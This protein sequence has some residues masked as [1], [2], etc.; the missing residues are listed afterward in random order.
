MPRRPMS[1][2]SLQLWLPEEPALATRE[3]LKHMRKFVWEG[4][5]LPAVRDQAN[6]ILEGVPGKAWRWQMHQL[7]NWVRD[8]ITYRLDPNGLETVQRADITLEL[9]YGD[10]DDFCVLLSTLLECCGYWTA[11]RALGFDQPGEFS[12]VIV[13]AQMPGETPLIALDA[14]EPQPMGWSPPGW[15]CEMFAPMS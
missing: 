1:P 15:T 12:H 9:G 14:T 4:M 11:F 7:F 6:L 2:P 3:T 13:V 8:N 5:R 10:C